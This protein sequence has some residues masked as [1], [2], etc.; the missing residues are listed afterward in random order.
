VLSLDVPIYAT[1][2]AAG[3]SLNHDGILVKD[4]NC[5]APDGAFVLGT[6]SGEPLVPSDPCHWASTM[7]G[8]PATTLEEIV[9]ALANQATRDASASV[10]LTV[11]GH[12]GKSIRLHVP[13]D[14]A[15]S[16]ANGFTDCDEGKFCTLSTGEPGECSMWYHGPDEFSELWVVDKDGEFVFVTGNSYPETPA[17]VIEEVQ[18]FLGSMTFSQ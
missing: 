11:D 15:F 12:P 6:W 13:G 10:D 16:D 8:T 2:P 17:E 5:C 7:P 9:A 18:A 4:G 1:I 14:I 3:W